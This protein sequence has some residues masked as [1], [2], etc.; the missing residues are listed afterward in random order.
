MVTFFSYI[1]YLVDI[2]GYM[3]LLAEHF[4]YNSGQFSPWVVGHFNSLYWGF[5]F[6]HGLFFFIYSSKYL[7][8]SP[9]LLWSLKVVLFPYNFL[10]TCGEISLGSIKNCVTEKAHNLKVI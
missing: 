1:H 9:T 5:I 3:S 2:F 4:C 6:Q 8:G 10:I 7:S